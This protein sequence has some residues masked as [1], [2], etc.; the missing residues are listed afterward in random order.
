MTV[1]GNKAVL[2]FRHVGEGLVARNGP[3][4]GFTIAGPDHKFHNAHAEIK[5]DQVVVWSDKVDKPVA[6]RYGWAIHPVVNLYNREGLPAT[7]FRSDF[8]EEWK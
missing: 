5:G 8:P 7:P 4:T 2:N 1:E 6:V 3:L